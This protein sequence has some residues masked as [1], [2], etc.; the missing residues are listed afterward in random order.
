MGFS[1]I[2]ARG[3]LERKEEVGVG[4]AAG[5]L[6]KNNKK[7]KIKL[8]LFESPSYSQKVCVKLFQVQASSHLLFI[9]D[10]D[11]GGYNMQVGYFQLVS[12]KCWVRSAQ[13]YTRNKDARRLV[14][15]LNQ[16]LSAT[17]TVRRLSA[18]CQ[19]NFFV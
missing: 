6:T 16:N 7:N 19:I 13:G 1:G 18:C 15:N 10:T 5:E 9:K 8:N 11:G 2:K 4:G 14:F 12:F 17:I 3:A